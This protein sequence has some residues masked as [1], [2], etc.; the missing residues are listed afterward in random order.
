MRIALDE[1]SPWT[2]RVIAYTIGALTLLLLL[3]AQG[4]S[5]AIPGG[6]NWLHV[7]AASV[8][9]VV[10][11]GL[12]AAFAQLLANTSRVIV[13]N[14]SMPVWASLMAYLVLRE[15]IDI[16][17]AIGLALCI[18]GLGILVFPAAAAPVH[19]PIG[20]LLALCCALSWGGGTVYMK[21]AR[22]KGD[23]LAITFWEI[24][25]G[26]I[27]FSIFSLIFDG[28][29][30]FAT[31]NVRTW[32]ALSYIGIFGT[33]FAFFIWFNIIGRLSTATASLGSLMNPVVG[34]IGAMILLGDRPTVQDL[35]GF[36]LIFGAAACVLIPRRVRPP[37]AVA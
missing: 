11:F 32:V 9:F 17:A 12:A 30:T 20:L 29:P 24:V 15:R 6:R 37:L 33:G 36:A 3:K 14:Y 25:I 13:I 21:W 28:T 5:L 8:I 16:R 18:A 22:I 31:L 2:M 19:E 27:A 35:T 10:C 26:L 4:R 23:L 1:V 7:V 34:V